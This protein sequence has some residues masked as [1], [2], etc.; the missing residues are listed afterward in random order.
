MLLF[1]GCAGRPAFGDGPLLSRRDS[2]DRQLVFFGGQGADAGAGE[3]PVAD[4]PVEFFLQESA[5]L[6]GQGEALQLPLLFQLGYQLGK[7]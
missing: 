2:Q 7:R 3:V 1:G 4:P 6:L 5:D